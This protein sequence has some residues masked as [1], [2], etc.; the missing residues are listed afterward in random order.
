MKLYEIRDEIEMLILSHVD[1]ETGELDEEVIDQ[2]TQLEVA[3]EEKAVNVGLFVKGLRSEAEAIKNEEK[4]LAARRGVLERQADHL[5][6]YLATHLPKGDPLKD[7]RVVISW[8]KSVAVG[9]YDGIE[10]EKDVPAKYRRKKVTI[11][12]DKR[13]ALADLK[14]GKKIKGLF[15]DQ[16][17]KLKVK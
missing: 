15:L 4:N 11:E 13:I 17:E 1:S 7:P 5:E 6:G 10:I 12:L 2:L 8:S 3:L 16:R 9:V 14:A